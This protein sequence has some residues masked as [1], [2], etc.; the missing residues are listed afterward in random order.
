M[1]Y[2]SVEDCEVDA[3]MT[4]ATAVVIR[5]RFAEARTNDIQVAVEIVG[6]EIDRDLLPRPSLQGPRLH[7]IIARRN[8]VGRRE[9]ASDLVTD[10]QLSPVGAEEGQYGGALRP[11]TGGR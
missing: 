8:E 1:K 4:G 3:R 6:Y 5:K 9:R 7:I 2:A 10:L 11:H